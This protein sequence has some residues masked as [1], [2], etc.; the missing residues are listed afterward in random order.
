MSFSDFKNKV[1][2]YN[3]KAVWVVHIGGHISFEIELISNYCKKGNLVV[4]RL[5]SFAWSKLEWENQVH[6]G[7]AGVYSMYA[8]KSI[9]TGEGGILVSKNDEL[10][11]YAKKFRNYG[12]FE[13]DVPGLNFRMTEFTAVLGVLAT[14]R[15][16]EIVS[17][18]NN[19]FSKKAF[20]FKI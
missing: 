3:P 12:K 6:G 5:R 2:E 13:H 9:S 11:D 20:R 8:T 18:K 10:M 19:R 1:N 7:D 16:D 14:K 15:L 17:W 4:G